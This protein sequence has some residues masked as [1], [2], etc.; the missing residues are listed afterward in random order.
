MNNQNTTTPA[1][2]TTPSAPVKDHA[3]QPVQAPKI[4]AVPAKADA[5]PAK[6]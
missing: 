5:I 3:V 6:V 2:T 1:A 4:E